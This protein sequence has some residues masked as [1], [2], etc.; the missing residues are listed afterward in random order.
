MK[1][2]VLVG[3]MLFP[4]G[5][6][7]PFGEMPRKVAALRLGLLI[8]SVNVTKMPRVSTTI[9]MLCESEANHCRVVTVAARLEEKARAFF[10]SSRAATVLLS[11]LG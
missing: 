3:G 1:D 11:R 4:L 10:K 9:V 6:F 7:V 2:F 8:A 5:I